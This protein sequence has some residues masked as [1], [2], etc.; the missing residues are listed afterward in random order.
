[1]TIE[2]LQKEMISAMKAK[3]KIRKDTVSS[4]IGNIKTTAINEN[5]R[6]DIPEALVDRVLLKE[7]KTMQEMIDTCPADRTET[8]AEYNQKMAIINEFV[9]KMMSEDEIKDKIYEVVLIKDIVEGNRGKIMKV[10]APVFK[11]KAEMKLVSQVVTEICSK[12][13]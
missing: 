7:K 6:N 12:V 4:I 3:D 9:P 11:G 8:L 13:K 1:M 10:I 2:I 5:C